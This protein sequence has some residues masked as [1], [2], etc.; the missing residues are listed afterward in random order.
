MNKG[1]KEFVFRLVFDDESVYMEKLIAEGEALLD[2]GTTCCPSSPLPEGIG[3]AKEA[4]KYILKHWMMRYSCTE[5]EA[6]H[7]LQAQID[8]FNDIEEA[9]IN[10]F[11]DIKD[12]KEFGKTATPLWLCTFCGHS[13]YDVDEKKQLQQL[14]DDKFELQQEIDRLRQLLLR[15]P[16]GLMWK[17]KLDTANAI[18]NGLSAISLGLGLEKDCYTITHTDSSSLKGVFVG[19]IGGLITQVKTILAELKE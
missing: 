3:S 7:K 11:N 13:L 5:E 1:T 18:L 10:R 9:R 17:D 19:T 6:R 12:K 14:D 15:R 2:E 8:R 16:T 4:S